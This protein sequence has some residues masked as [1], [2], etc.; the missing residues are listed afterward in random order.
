MN[1]N[2][3]ILAMLLAFAAASASA[4]TTGAAQG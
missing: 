1:K 4:Q 2:N 3:A